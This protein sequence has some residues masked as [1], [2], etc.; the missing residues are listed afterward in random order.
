MTNTKKGYDKENF[1]DINDKL[2]TIAQ[3]WINTAC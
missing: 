1:L 2:I 3:H